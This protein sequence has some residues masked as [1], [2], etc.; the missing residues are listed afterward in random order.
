[1]REEVR[2]WT[3]PKDPKTGE[4]ERLNEAFRTYASAYLDFVDDNI[5]HFYYRNVGI[6]PVEELEDETEMIKAYIQGAIDIIKISVQN[7]YWKAFGDIYNEY[8]A[9]QEYAEEIEN[10]V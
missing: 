2:E 5:G 8:P 7:G 1:M 9:L 6:H 10:A 4:S 3:S